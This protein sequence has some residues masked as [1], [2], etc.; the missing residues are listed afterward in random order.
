MP[1]N[2][3]HQEQTQTLQQQQ[4][5]LVGTQEVQTSFVNSIDIDTSDLEAVGGSRTLTINANPNSVFNI[6]LFDNS[7][8]VKFYNFNTNEFTVGFDTTKNL[9][10]LMQGET[11]QKNIIFPASTSANYNIL[12]YSLPNS[13]TEIQSTTSGSKNIFTTSLSQIGDTTVTFTPVTHNTSNYKTFPTSTRVA[14]PITEDS[15]T[16][17]IN[18]TVENVENDSHGFGLDL[19]IQ[20]TANFFIFRTTETV[21]GAVSSGT[22]VVVD[23][24]TDIVVG[25]VITKVSSGSLSG[26]PSITEID[27]VTKTLTIS[28]A[29]TFADG[30]TLTIEAKGA[31]IIQKAIGCDFVVNSISAQEE[32]LT[33]TVRTDSDGSATIALNGTYGVGKGSAI[34]GLNV[35]NSSANIVQSVSASSSAGTITA[36]VDQ[37]NISQG[38]ILTFTTCRKINIIASVTITQQPRANRTINLDLDRFIAVNVGS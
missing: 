23:D 36:Q 38:T 26:E 37:I 15:E 34:K 16:I 4:P 5:Q 8:P 28:S 21:N 20:P 7:D 11:F 9:K 22:S 29:Q 2:I 18:F 12:L 17:N 10:V 1:H 31:D 30:I 35:D 33:K 13:S 25:M 14:P 19:D 27:T 3:Y 6:Q 24:L 32:T